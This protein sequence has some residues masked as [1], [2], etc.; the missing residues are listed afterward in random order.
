MSF[1]VFADGRMMMEER[2]FDLLMTLPVD[3]KEHLLPRTL[4]ERRDIPSDEIIREARSIE[5]VSCFWGYE[6][7]RDAIVAF[8]DARPQ[9][10]WACGDKHIIEVTN[11]NATKGNG[12]AWLCGHLG[13]DLARAWAFGDSENDVTM[14]ERAGVGVALANSM[15]AALDAADQVTSLDNNAG[16]LGRHLMGMLG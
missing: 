10:A 12:L 1:D 8:V 5:R 6:A 11:V 3:P 14:L 16:G 13:V 2:Y 15:Q 9:L 7:D 4:R